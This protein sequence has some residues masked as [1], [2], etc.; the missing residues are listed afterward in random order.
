MK[1][2]SAILLSLIP[3]RDPMRSIRRTAARSRMAIRDR[4]SLARQRQISKSV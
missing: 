4:A 3:E 1:G 2:P